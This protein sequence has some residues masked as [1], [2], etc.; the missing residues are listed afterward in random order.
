[1]RLTDSK[2][3]STNDEFAKRGICWIEV[4]KSDLKISEKFNFIYKLMRIYIYL[5]K[6]SQKYH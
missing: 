4:Q 3:H 2:F 1:M 5:Y 6:F